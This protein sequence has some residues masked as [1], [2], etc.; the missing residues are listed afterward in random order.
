MCPRRRGQGLVPRLV[1]A[2]TG[3][4]CLCP[5]ASAREAIS[6]CPLRRESHGSESAGRTSRR[7]EGARAT[8]PRCAAGGRAR[9][10]PG[11]EGSGSSAARQGWPGPLRSRSALRATGCRG[12]RL[13]AERTGPPDPG[14]APPRPGAA[15]SPRKAPGCWGRDGAREGARADSPPTLGGFLPHSA[16]PSRATVTGPSPKSLC[17]H[18]AR[19]GRCACHAGYGRGR[20]RAF[21]GCSA[22][23]S[24]YRKLT[25]SRPSGLT[26]VTFLPET[27]VSFS[28]SPQVGLHYITARNGKC[29]CW[30]PAAA[31]ASSGAPHS[32]PSHPPRAPVLPGRISRSALS[33]SAPAPSPP[34]SPSGLTHLSAAKKIPAVLGEGAG[35]WRAARGAPRLPDGRGS[36]A[37]SCSPGAL[38]KRGSRA[39]R[40]RLPRPRRPHGLPSGPAPSSGQLP[41]SNAFGPFCGLRTQGASQCPGHPPAGLLPRLAARPARGPGTS[42]EPAAGVRGLAALRCLGLSHVPRPARREGREPRLEAQPNGTLGLHPGTT[43]WPAGPGARGPSSHPSMPSSEQPSPASRTPTPGPCC[44]RPSWPGP[45]APVSSGPGPPALQAGSCSPPPPRD[46]ASRGRRGKLRA[47]EGSSTAGVSGPPGSPRAAPSA[48]PVRRTPMQAD[49]WW[50]SHTGRPQGTWLGLRPQ[51]GPRPEEFPKTRLESPR[52]LGPAVNSP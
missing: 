9:S 12:R 25:F 27:R 22:E 39:A 26:G 33:A 23:F 46:Q 41:R 49:C 5:E 29:T 38:K 1:T 52:L 21:P 14:S 20:Q 31:V 7:E 34:P 47:R 16:R 17:G 4:H 32:G 45:R 11:T 44:P 15:P 28:R 40:H 30:C 42:P 50:E 35:S 43:A 6:A 37:V 10:S 48:R 8:A 51:K 24:H 36:G 18:T 13:G 19:S 3:R 2:R